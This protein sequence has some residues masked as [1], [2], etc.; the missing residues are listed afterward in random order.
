[1]ALT[2]TEVVDAAV[3]IL[4]TWGLA[5]LTMR[6]LAEA[7]GVRAGALYWHYPNKQS[8]LAGVADAILA[9]VPP[10]GPGPWPDAVGAW[11]LGLRAALLDHRDSADVVASTRAMGLVSVDVAG[12]AAARLADGGLPDAEARA[13]AQA[14]VRYV[15]GHVAE[16]QAQADFDRLGPGRAGPQPERVDAASF[17]FGVRLLLD[18]V[19]A[20]HPR[21][22]P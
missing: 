14:L 11:A 9:A 6:R 12:P 15:L 13:A 5:D 16:E 3:A 1:M 17:A 18:G 2:R 19:G 8:L 22:T 7:L 21:V 20:L 4:D 10:P